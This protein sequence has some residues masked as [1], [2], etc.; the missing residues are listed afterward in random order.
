MSNLIKWSGSKDSQAENI[1]NFF[2][3]KIENYHEPFI[4]GGSIFL[5][6]LESNTD[7]NSYFISDI[8][9]ELIGIYDLILNDPYKIITNYETHH[10]AFNSKDIKFRK[11]YFSYIR[12]R[13]NTSKL[14]ED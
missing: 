3:K 7:I 4:G 8:N 5:K 12:E 14:P 9:K 10:K 11:E 1:I 6:L 2:P 13:F